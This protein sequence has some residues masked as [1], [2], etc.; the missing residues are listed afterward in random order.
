[1]AKPKIR[2]FV[3]D[4]LAEGRDC[5][6]TE[7]Q[8]HYLRNVMRCQIGDALILF[9]GKDGAF[10]STISALSKK[11][12]MVTV[13]KQIEPYRQG[14]E[15]ILLTAPLKKDAMDIVIEKATELGVSAIQPIITA[16]TQSDRINHERL[17]AQMIEASEQSE[18]LDV[19]ALFKPQKLMDFLSSLKTPLLFCDE[20]LRTQSGADV[21][22]IIKQHIAK[23]APLMVLI[24]PEGGFSEAEREAM[25]QHPNCYA[26]SL[27][28]T[29][30]R[31]ETA[32]ISALTLTFYAL[33]N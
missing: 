24:G 2:L 9:N 33:N 30:L 6:L 19:P 28:P 17:Q 11:A 29:V 13:E 7:Q 15:V 8:T 14:H 20:S 3:T 32:A 12:A 26:V 21:P 27:G 22:S 31:A 16:Y 4:A 25:R 23:A 18:R 5:L 1:M 10:V